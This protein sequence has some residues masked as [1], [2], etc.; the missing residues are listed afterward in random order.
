LYVLGYYNLIDELTASEAAG[1][2]AFLDRWGDA[3]LAE[4]ELA[5]LVILAHHDDLALDSH[6]ALRIG[7]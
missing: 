5:S 4:L 2:S 7:D 1:L 3:T 6:A